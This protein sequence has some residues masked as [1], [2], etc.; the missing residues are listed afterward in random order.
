MSENA[1]KVYLACPY[2]H[3]EDAVQEARFHQANRAAGVL[4]K[5][6][7]IVY[8]SISHSRPIALEVD[9][10][11]GW[12]FWERIDRVFVEW[13][14]ALIVLDIDGWKE[15]V[16]VQAEIAYAQELEKIIW[17]YSGMVGADGG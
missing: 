10:P 5:L 16:G 4:M 8:S 1:V 13:C 17:P 11:H 15:S 14:D 7:Y 9:M 6:G 3:D 12:S 2:S